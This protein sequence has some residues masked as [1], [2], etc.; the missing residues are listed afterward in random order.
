MSARSFIFDHVWLKLFSLILATLIWMAVH[1]NLADD[2]AAARKSTRQFLDHPILL[3]TETAG[4]RAYRL[5]PAR[6]NV[7]VQGRADLLNMLKDE[8]IQA[9]FRRRGEHDKPLD[10]V[11]GV[12]ELGVVIVES[13]EPA[14]R[15]GDGDDGLHARPARRG[16]L[17]RGVVPSVTFAKIVREQQRHVS[18]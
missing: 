6:A 18:R 15:K 17:K 3:L 14:I 2:P 9:I 4:R 1:T 12:E 8:D 5:E 16:L 11:C 13:K 10:S 7:F